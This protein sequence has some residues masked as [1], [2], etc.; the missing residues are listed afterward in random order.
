MTY[1]IQPTTLGSTAFSTFMASSDMNTRIPVRVRLPKSSRT[2]LITSMP[3]HQPN[4]EARRAYAREYG[5]ESPA[6]TPPTPPKRLTRFT[7]AELMAMDFP[8]LTFIVDGLFPTGLILTAGAP[9][10]GKSW[11]FLCL[12]VSV[13]SGQPFLGRNTFQGDVLYLALEDTG[14]RLADRLAKVAPNVNFDEIP[15]QFWTQ[16]ARAN[17]GGLQDIEDWLSAASKP[18]LVII[19][20]WGR[21]ALAHRARPRTSTT[22]LPGQCNPCRSWR[23]KYGI[24]ICLVHHTRKSAGDGAV[25]TD[26]FDGVLGSQALTSNMDAT[27]ILTRIRMEK[28]AILKITGR[29]IEEQQL[30]LTFDRTTFHWNEVDRP[31]APS[32]SPER[33]KVLDAVTAGCT[34]TGDIVA[35]VGKG[36]TACRTYSKSFATMAS[37]KA[38]EKAFTDCPDQF[39]PGLETGAPG[40]MNDPGDIAESVL[41]DL[42]WSPVHPLSI[43]SQGRPRKS[44]LALFFSP[45]KET[46][47]DEP[48]PDH[49]HPRPTPHP[50]GRVRHAPRRHAPDHPHRWHAGGG[51]DGCHPGLPGL[52]IAQA[53]GL[54][55]HAR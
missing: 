15:L 22:T 28:D 49:L 17:E 29:D 8:E 18:K 52:R 35:H 25:S 4:R 13:A 12:A 47:H 16:C 19:D 33:Q 1:A 44:A 45:P 41:A 23:N 7:A 31:L 14:K 30:S 34:T 10:I 26:P 6:I 11:W 9:K 21:F 42:I 48:Q 53:P 40:D 55:V 39:V 24:A 51:S 38:L 3:S 32:L 36:R 2:S 5:Q 20:V 50:A 27:M 46:H 54:H 43:P 37:S